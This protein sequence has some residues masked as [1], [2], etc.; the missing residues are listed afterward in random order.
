MKILSIQTMKLAD[1]EMPNIPV[2]P[3]PDHVLHPQ[4][5]THYSLATVDELSDFQ[6]AQA[7]I[8][9]IREISQRRKQQSNSKEQEEES[10]EAEL[11]VGGLRSNRLTF[12]TRSSSSRSASRRVLPEVA[13]GRNPPPVRR[14]I[15]IV[16]SSQ[17]NWENE[18]E[19]EEEEEEDEDE[20]VPIGGESCEDPVSFQ[21]RTRK[22]NATSSSSA[23][24]LAV[25]LSHLDLNNE[26]AEEGMAPRTRRR[27][28]A[29][30]EEEEKA[31]EKEKVSRAPR[32]RPLRQILT[33]TEYVL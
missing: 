4:R 32:I 18:E 7:A 15:R 26:E 9:S 17:G 21:R 28:E 29:K 25:H 30:E 1:E 13:V 10:N 3:V 2:R 16:P 20:K 27:G 23:S 22:S 14:R 11:A 12:S 19:E 6:N 33:D 31:K 5:Y 8:A 24:S